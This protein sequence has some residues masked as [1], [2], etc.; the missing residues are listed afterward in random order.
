MFVIHNKYPIRHFAHDLINAIDYL[1]CNR[2]QCQEESD[3]ANDEVY[4]T[5]Q[6]N[7][8]KTELS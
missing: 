8:N 5:R 4:S 7:K 6:K 3:A 1:I 2:H